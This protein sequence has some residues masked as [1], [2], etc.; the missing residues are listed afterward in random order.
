MLND[1]SISSIDEDD[2]HQEV[3]IKSK[4]KRSNLVDHD[5]DLIGVERCVR[6]IGACLRPEG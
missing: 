4:F 6:A 3:L 2:S 5:S 1:Q